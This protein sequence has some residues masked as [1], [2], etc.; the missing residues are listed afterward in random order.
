MLIRTLSMLLALAIVI[1][2]CTFLGA[3]G[4]AAG[5]HGDA[6]GAVAGHA[7]GAP[8]T[9]LH[10]PR[11][12][13]GLD[14]R[15]ATDCHSWNVTTVATPKSEPVEQFWFDSGAFHAASSISLIE[16]SSLHEPPRI[17]TD[18]GILA[19]DRPVYASSERY[20]I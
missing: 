20:R 10:C 15:C 12:P 8:A 3:I 19:I 13:G 4:G 5:H 1:A 16:P 6:H 7:H 17:D 18:F 2:P 11:H 14:H 9:A